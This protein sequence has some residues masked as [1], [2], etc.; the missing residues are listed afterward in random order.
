MNR[1]LLISAVLLTVGCG[2]EPSAC[3]DSSFAATPS[4]MDFGDLRLPL[5]AMPDSDDTVPVDEV[6]FVRNGCGQA[7]VIEQ[8]CLYQ[9]GHNGSENLRAFEFEFNRTVWQAG[10][11][12][13]MADLRVGFH[14]RNVRLSCPGG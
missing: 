11:G 6:I 7:V 13:C 9:R 2:D 4:V 1:V 8:V 5:P 3:D 12:G 10:S 14:F